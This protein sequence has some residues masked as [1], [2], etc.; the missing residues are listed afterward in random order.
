MKYCVDYSETNWSVPLGVKRKS[1]TV[2][3]ESVN[4]AVKKVL[5][6]TKGKAFNFVVKIL[7]N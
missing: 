6:E 7:E 1:S 5:M 2:E 3:A 4:D